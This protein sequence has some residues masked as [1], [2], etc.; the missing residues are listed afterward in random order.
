MAWLSGGSRKPLGGSRF[1]AAF[2]A[3]GV[4]ATETAIYPLRR[5]ATS[6]V[7]ILGREV[8]LHGSISAGWV[9]VDG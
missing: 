3:S 6:N 9:R 5:L 1:L 8:Q 2:P 7:G 4:S